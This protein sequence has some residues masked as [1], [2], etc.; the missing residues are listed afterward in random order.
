MRNGTIE[1]RL[2]YPVKFW[3]VHYFKDRDIGFSFDQMAMLR[4]LKNNGIDMPGY[5]E[6][7]KK[8][9]ANIVISETMFAAAESYCMDRFLKPNFTKK[10]LLSA[11]NECSEETKEL[12]VQCWKDA[13]ELG[14]KEL[15]GKKKAVRH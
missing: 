14:Y 4:M 13:E 11:F 3:G 8:T 6:W 9:N 15:P 5:A 10:G 1:V 12:I 2:P 7:R